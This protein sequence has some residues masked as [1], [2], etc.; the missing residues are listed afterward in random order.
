MPSAVKQSPSAWV[1][2]RVGGIHPAAIKVNRPGRST[3]SISMGNVDT[4]G[5]TGPSG[6]G[7]AG[8]ALLSATGR[9]RSAAGSLPFIDPVGPARWPD[10]GGRPVAG[11][12]DPPVGP[13]APRTHTPLARSQPPAGGRAAGGLHDP[14]ARIDAGGR[15]PAPPARRHTAHTPWLRA[16]TRAVPAVTPT[17]VRRI[18]S[19]NRLPGHRTVVQAAPRPISGRPR[20]RR[21]AVSAVSVM[22]GEPGG[23]VAV[24]AVGWW[25][26]ATWASGGSTAPLA[27]RGQ[28]AAV[29]TARQRAGRPGQ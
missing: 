17:A 24:T 13:S 5:S 23:R 6:S 16:G 2:R 11:W 12:V 7:N 15:P 29:A 28:A 4:V 21:W 1:T 18:E 9:R 20:W 10:G 14:A 26:P 25:G 19:G 8:S 22:P 3:S 27:S